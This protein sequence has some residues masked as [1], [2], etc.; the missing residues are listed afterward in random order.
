MNYRPYILITNDDGVYAPG[1]KQLWKALSPHADLVVVAPSSEQSAV[2]LSIT[3]R[4]PLGIKKEEWPLAKDT[5]IWSIN[6]TP[7]DCVKLALSVILPKPPQL[8]VSGI[9]RGSNAG[10]NVLYSGTVAGVIEGVMHNIPG[11]AFSV[12]DYINPDYESVEGYILPIIKYVLDNPLPFGTLFNVNFPK[13][14]KE[15]IKG[16]RLATQGKEYWTEDPEHREH[17]MEKN[18]YYWLGAKLAQFNEEADSD[19]SLLN[20]GFATVVPILISD[21][22]HQRYVLDQKEKFEIAVNTNVGKHFC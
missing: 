10:R 18:S 11:I 5:P 7:A 8:I 16:I 22:T 13:N 3:I 6:G 1:I 14:L 17:P 12:S 4:H 15:E 20:Q 9:N 19:I 21:L 2:S